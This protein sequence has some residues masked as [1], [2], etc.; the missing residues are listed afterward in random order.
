MNIGRSPQLGIPAVTSAQ[1]EAGG[2]TVVIPID[3]E[4]YLYGLDIGFIG[5]LTTGGGNAA[6]INAE[7]PQSLINRIRVTSNHEKFGGRQRVNISGASAF[8]RSH[9][10]NGTAP[11][12]VST[13]AVAQAAYD[14]I[15]HWPIVFPVENL[16]DMET[17]AQ[18]LDA[19]HCGSLQLELDINP[20]AALAPTG[21]ATTYAWANFGGGG[22]PGFFVNLLQP[23]GYKGAPYTS[24]V[25]KADRNDSLV[26]AVALGNQIGN[27]LV[28]GGALTRLWLKQYVTDP[29]QAVDVAATMNQPNTQAAV[30]LSR[31]QFQINRKAIREFLVW[32]QLEMENK[33]D[34]ETE[35]WPAGY[36]LIGFVEGALGK[37]GKMADALD[38]ALFQLQKQLVTVGGLNNALANGRLE[39]GWEQVLP[40]PGV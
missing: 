37:S 11:L 40:I 2:L 20:G 38:T 35:A 36:G 21:G 6:A 23:N 7:A 22:N 24:F 12:V 17:Q 31:P 18:L 28:L 10:M 26:N 1:I 13:L 33:V 25:E 9:A 27:E 5:R 30:G 32:R 3:R 14:M 34:Y 19:P 16:G 39:V 8:R 15:V 4:Q 29:L